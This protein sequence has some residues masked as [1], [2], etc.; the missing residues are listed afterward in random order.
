M[1]KSDHSVSDQLRHRENPVEGNDSDDS[2]AQESPGSPVLSAQ[3]H[4]RN[5]HHEAAHHKK[6]IDTDRAK[7]K[8]LFVRVMQ[9]NHNC[10]N[11]SQD[12]DD[13]NLARLSPTF[14]QSGKMMLDR[15][16]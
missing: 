2:L 7:R 3:L 5:D 1:M 14:I 10:R 9:D 16:G 6:Y 11:R 8:G 15:G 13:E 12:L 4:G